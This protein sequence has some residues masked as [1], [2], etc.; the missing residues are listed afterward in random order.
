MKVAMPGDLSSGW[1]SSEVLQKD[2][3]GNHT[4][5]PFSDALCASGTMPIQAIN[6]MR[7]VQDLGWPKAK[8]VFK[9]K[10]G[11][12][13]IVKKDEVIWLLKCKPKCWRLYFYVWKSKTEKRLIYVHAVCKQ[14]DAE[15]PGNTI[16]ARRIADGIRPGESAITAFRFPV[17]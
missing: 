6:K 5:T 16:A 10:H 14:S 2:V 4:I 3:H 15:D 9:D 7:M 12:P 1:I 17:G 8:H 13:L 11:H